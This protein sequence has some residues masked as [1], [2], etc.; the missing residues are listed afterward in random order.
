MLERYFIFMMISYISGIDICVFLINFLRFLKG[1]YENIFIIMYHSIVIDAWE[2]CRSFHRCWI[3]RLAVSSW[4]CQRESRPLHKSIGTKRYIQPLPEQRVSH[5]N[6]SQFHFWNQFWHGL[7]LGQFSCRVGRCTRQPSL[8]I[9]LSKNSM[10][11]FVL[12][13]NLSIRFNKH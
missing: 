2:Q 1:Q 10:I 11:I 8:K 13:R 6:G 7:C 9:I 3:N 12:I 4:C 5:Q